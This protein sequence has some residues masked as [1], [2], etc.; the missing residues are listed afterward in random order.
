[1]VKGSGRRLKTSNIEQLKR[2]DIKILD[3][4]K[5]EEAR[6]QIENIRAQDPTSRPSQIQEVASQRG[7]PVEAFR[8]ADVPRQQFQQQVQQSEPRARPVTAESVV[9]KEKAIGDIKLAQEAQSQSFTEQ[10][11]EGLTGQQKGI[12]DLAIQ[13]VTPLLKNHPKIANKLIKANQSIK[14][15][16]RGSTIGTL[17]LAGELLPRNIRKYI[18][19][20]GDVEEQLK[21][22]KDAVEDALKDYESGFASYSDVFRTIQKHGLL[23]N[24][25]TGVVHVMNKSPLARF[26]EKGILLEAELEQQ[27]RDL[28]SLQRELTAGAITNIRS[29]GSA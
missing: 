7:I 28:L 3:P 15:N 19:I 11:D 26:T 16:I 13:A 23:V 18:T 6:Q 25:L 4:A 29:S 8:P 24:E 1:M 20:K 10:L 2:K 9:Q 5:N 17:F 12:G 21:L 22:S 27:R 14:E